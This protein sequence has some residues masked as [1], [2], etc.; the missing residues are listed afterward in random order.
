MMPMAAATTTAS[1]L[2]S[3]LSTPEFCG[4]SRSLQ[5][6]QRQ[7]RC[8]S[9]SVHWKISASVNLKPPPYSLHALEPHM[10]KETLEYHWGKHHRAYVDN[11]NKQIEGTELDEM[12]LETIISTSYNKGDVLP[13]FNNAAQVWNHE[14]FWES[15][16]PNGGG[17]PSGELLALINRDFGSFGGLINEFKSAATTQFGSG[18]AWLVYKEHKLDIPNARN[19]RP[20]EEDKKLVVVKSPN[21]VNPLVWEYHPL[22][23]IDV[24]EHAYYLDFE[25]RRPDYISVFLDKLVSWEAVSLRLEAAKVLVAEREKEMAEIDAVDDVDTGEPEDADN[26]YFGSDPEEFLD[27]E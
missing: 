23:A 15:M 21:A 2:T 27:D 10:S 16:K 26:M 8:T 11:L 9:R 17:K 25:N 24:W 13:A 14:F 7:R 18:W 5:G 4:L 12:T 6:P 20:S 3:F 1:H 19:P 22:L